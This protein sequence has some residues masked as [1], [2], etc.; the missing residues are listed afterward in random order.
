MGS[1]VAL[2]LGSNL[3]DRMGF[4][5]LARRRIEDLIR[6]IRFSSVYETDP[7]GVRDQPRF[8]NACCVGVAGH[9]PG[10]LLQDLKRIERE[11]GRRPGGARCGPRELD[12]DILLYGAEIIADPALRIP[13]PRLAERA[14][15]LVPLAEIA[16]DWVEPASGLT[17]TELADRIDS[18]GVSLAGEMPGRHG[19]GPTPTGRERPRPANETTGPTGPN[20]MRGRRRGW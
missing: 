7:D 10:E 12:L 13:H 9:T 2:G 3:G 11:A 18:S 16:A 5:G 15:V 6:D 1:L 19:R 20:E 8:L 4:L 14:F 17:I